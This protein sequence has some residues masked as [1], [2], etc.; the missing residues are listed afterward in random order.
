[1]RVAGNDGFIMKCRNSVD[2]R[3]LT[4]GERIRIG[5]LPEDCRA[6]DAA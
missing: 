5:W 1:M 2:Q 4:P 6:L 3:K